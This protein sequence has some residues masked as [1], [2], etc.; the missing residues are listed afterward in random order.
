MIEVDVF[1]PL[2][3][4]ENLVDDLIKS[5]FMQK[6]IKINKNALITCDIYDEI[7]VYGFQYFIQKALGDSY[8]TYDMELTLIGTKEG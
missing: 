3:N 2:Y 4:A 5:I 1:V 6:N 8:C 7:F